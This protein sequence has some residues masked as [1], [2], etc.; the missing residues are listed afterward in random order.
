M[1]GDVRP[2]FGEDKIGDFVFAEFRVE[3]GSFRLKHRILGQIRLGAAH[4]QFQPA[5]VA[6]SAIS[7]EVAAIP[8]TGSP[9]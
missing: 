5:R 7:S 8:T 2:R 9:T 1:V 3:Q 4:I 6:S